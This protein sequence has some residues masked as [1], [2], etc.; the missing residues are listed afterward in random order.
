MFEQLLHVFVCVLHNELKEIPDF[1][2][3]VDWS[4]EL[5]PRQKSKYIQ[6]RGLNKD[7]VNSNEPLVQLSMLNALSIAS[8]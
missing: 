4:W 8:I 1:I 3:P 2:R 6:V 7:S 5:I